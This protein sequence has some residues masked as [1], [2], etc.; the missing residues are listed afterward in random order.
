MSKQGD[1]FNLI[2]PNPRLLV[3]EDDEQFGQM[4]EEAIAGLGVKVFREPDGSKGLNA[5][6]ECNPDVVL[7]DLKMPRLG[8]EG[9]LVEL[10]RLGFSKPVIVMT[11]YDTSS[12]AMLAVRYGVIDVLE[13]PFAHERLISVLRRAFEIEMHRLLQDHLLKVAFN[14]LIK[15]IPGTNPHELMLKLDT[16]ARQALARGRSQEG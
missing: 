12:F 14:H 9:M 15:L 11:G 8:G 2:I 16:E 6:F 4:L 7:T 10:A 1:N 5:A 13:K 3:V